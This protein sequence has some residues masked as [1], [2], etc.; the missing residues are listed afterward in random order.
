MI[1]MLGPRIRTNP[2][3]THSLNF[4]KP[5]LNVLNQGAGI[6]WQRN[7]C[8]VVV[9]VVVMHIFVLVLSMEGAS[10]LRLAL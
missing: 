1:E 7:W 2:T 9:V 10:Y 4:N 5:M 3:K 6:P 8:V